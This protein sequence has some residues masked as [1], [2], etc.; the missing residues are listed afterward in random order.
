MKRIT[1]LL[2]EMGTDE[3]CFKFTK[4]II[5]TEHLQEEH[6]EIIVRVLTAL[7]LDLEK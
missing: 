3:S 6:A 1:L 5:R 4:L 7:W 2:L